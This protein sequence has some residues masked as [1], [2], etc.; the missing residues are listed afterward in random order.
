ML[1]WSKTLL[2]LHILLVKRDGLN[3]LLNKFKICLVHI[4]TD[5]FQNSYSV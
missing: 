3:I 4:V 5:L 2:L 1:T